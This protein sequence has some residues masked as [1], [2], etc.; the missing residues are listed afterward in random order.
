MT[1]F[2]YTHS[3]GFHRENLTSI[4]CNHHHRKTSF[5]KCKTF[6]HPPFNF[7]KLC[8]LRNGHINKIKIPR[9][10]V[11]KTFPVSVPITISCETADCREYKIKT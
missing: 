1:L 5:V 8:L 7:E 9:S 3:K 6:L 2:L 10:V 11:I 4:P